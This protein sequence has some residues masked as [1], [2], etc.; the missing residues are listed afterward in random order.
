MTQE[1]DGTIR[2]TSPAG[3]DHTT[4]PER[5]FARPPEHAHDTDGME[6]GAA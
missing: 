5:P 1:P 6:R 3:H 2:W 4:Q